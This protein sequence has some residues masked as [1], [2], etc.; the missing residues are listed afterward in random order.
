LGLTKGLLFRQG[1]LVLPWKTLDRAKTADGSEL[2]LAL[3]GTHYAIRIGG[4]NLM[5]SESH[6]SEEQLAVHGCEGLAGRKGVRVLVGGLGMGFT[7][8]AALDAVA[9]DAEVEVV[10]LVSAVVRWNRD[11]LAALAGAPLADRRVRVIE[12]DVGKTIERSA[13]RYDAILL[14]VDNGPEAFTSHENR[15]LYTAYGLGLARRALRPHG[16]F[17]VW[18]AFEDADFAE[19]LRIAGFQVQTRRVRAQRTGGGGRHV[20]WLARAGH[21]VPG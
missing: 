1:G 15:R 19:R 4:Q 13:S 10:E 5:S 21:I 18:S 20:L 6:D 7:V 11:P 2:T 9:A 3:R 16:V 17:A 8:R 14:D 12:G